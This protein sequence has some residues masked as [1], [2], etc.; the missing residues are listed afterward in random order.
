MNSPSYF[1]NSFHILFSLLQSKQF[2]WQLYLPALRSLCDHSYPHQRH[3][4]LHS[5]LD[6][7]ES[8]C[9]HHRNEILLICAELSRPWF[10]CWEKGGVSDGAAYAIIRTYIHGTLGV[11]GRERSSGSYLSQHPCLAPVHLPAYSKNT[12][13]GLQ[14]PALFK[15]TT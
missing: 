9:L 13:P 14:Q 8:I 7:S 15:R 1:L 3:L 10:K 12:C 6:E 2:L 11:Q 4:G 5:L